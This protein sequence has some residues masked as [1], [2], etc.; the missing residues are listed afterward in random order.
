MKKVI[1]TYKPLLRDNS[2]YQIVGVCSSRFFLVCVNTYTY[3]KTHII[4]TSTAL[5]NM[6][7]S[8]NI[9]P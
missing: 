7:L 4:I 8:A 3:L 5:C 1:I 2:Y 6:F 9:T